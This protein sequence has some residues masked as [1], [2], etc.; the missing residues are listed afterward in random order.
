MS[1][2]FSKKWTTTG[3]FSREA[4]I[5][6]KAKDHCTSCGWIAVS[7]AQ[8]AG[9]LSDTVSGTAVCSLWAEAVSVGGGGPCRRRPTSSILSR[10]LVTL[11]MA[12]YSDSSSASP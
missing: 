8:G 5:C 9:S 6:S 10:R 7:G 2:G 12:R 1:T 4:R 3:S 11:A